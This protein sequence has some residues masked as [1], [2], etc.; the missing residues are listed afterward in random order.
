MAAL[1][2]VEVIV[3]IF[4]MIV[5]IGGL[6]FCNHAKMKAELGRHRFHE[7]NIK[8]INAEFKEMNT[9]TVATTTSIK[10]LEAMLG[11][12]E[13]EKISAKVGQL[14]NNLDN[15]EGRIDRLG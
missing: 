7:A 2:D 13:L 10:K 1:F 6:L 15:L 12:K 9:I 14:E 3:P 11:P 8:P 4:A 5:A